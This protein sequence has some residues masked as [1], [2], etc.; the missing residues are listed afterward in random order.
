MIDHD[1]VFNL[2]AFAAA[3]TIQ[4][5]CLSAAHHS[6]R[7]TPKPITAAYV[8][9]F[10]GSAL[11]LFELYRGEHEFN[12]SSLLVELGVALLLSISRRRSEKG[13]PS[14]HMQPYERRRTHAPRI[15]TE[16]RADELIIDHHR[17]N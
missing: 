1:L 8:M 15:G 16:R 11:S 6:T 10:A 3:I 13:Y 4:W 5:L 7:S 17:I 14:G 12:P 2:L 9:I